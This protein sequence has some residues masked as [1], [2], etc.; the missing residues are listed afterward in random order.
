M[1]RIRTLLLNR[2]ALLCNVTTDAASWRRFEP[3]LASFLNTLPSHPIAQSSWRIGEGPRFEALAIPASVNYVGKGGNLYRLGLRPSGAAHVVV[4]YLRTTWLWDKVRVQGGAYGGFCTLDH[5]SG[6]FTFLSYRDPNLLETLDIYD[7]TADFLKQA[8][9]DEAELLRNIIGTI[10]DIDTYQLA[11][12]KGFTSMQR[13]LAGESDDIRQRRRDE[14]LGASVADFRAFADA[15]AEL[16][17]YGQVVVLGS[18]QAIQ[19]ANARRPGFLH[20]AQVV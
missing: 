8:G 6:N 3:E 16:T 2:G 15:V 14:I 4:I 20:V 9:P 1:E 19:A 5:R 11:D 17:A 7:Q 10:G 13:Y 18:E 12:A